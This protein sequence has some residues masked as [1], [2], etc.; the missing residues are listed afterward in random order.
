MGFYIRNIRTVVRKMSLSELSRRVKTTKSH[1]STIEQNRERPSSKLMCRIADALETPHLYNIYL[2]Q[3]FPEI[4]RLHEKGALFS[5]KD[6]IGYTCSVNEVATTY[7]DDFLSGRITAEKAVESMFAMPSLQTVPQN[8]PEFKNKLKTA[9][10]EIDRMLLQIKPLP[11][12]PYKRIRTP[13]KKKKR[14]NS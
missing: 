8:N 1:I 4:K 6:N 14:A 2:E 7:I 12:P 10:L 5:K 13:S 11:L 3:R 9:L